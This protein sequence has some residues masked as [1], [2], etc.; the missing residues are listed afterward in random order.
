[1][2]RKEADNM[3][4]NG[5]RN[6]LMVLGILL[7]TLLIVV[8]LIPVS[9]PDQAGAAAILPMVTAGAVVIE[10]ALE[11]FWTMVGKSR[12]GNWWPPK[13]IG[14]PP[15]PIGERLNTFIDQLN[16]PLTDFHQ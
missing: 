2:R 11:G 16:K 9:V 14:R 15:K 7:L 8:A 3:T 12:L 10:R 1:M 6:T 13:P 5:G 4:S